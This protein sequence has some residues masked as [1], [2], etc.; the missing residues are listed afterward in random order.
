[1]SLT[2]D[3]IRTE[4]QN[5]KLIGVKVT[6][7]LHGSLVSW[8]LAVR[9]YNPTAQQLQGEKKA[10]ELLM[11]WCKLIFKEYCI[12]LE[13][14]VLTSCSDSGSDVKRALKVVF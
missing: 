2:L 14:H 13:K 7:I 1:M 8:N 12:C 6:Y 10:S 11:E 5:K 4:V 3:L 9:A